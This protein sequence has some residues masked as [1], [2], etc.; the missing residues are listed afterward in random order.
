MQYLKL[1]SGK[2]PRIL[3]AD[4]RQSTPLNVDVL[5]SISPRTKLGLTIYYASH[6]FLNDTFKDIKGSREV[7]L[8]LI[9]PKWP[10]EDMSN[11][12]GRI[13]QQNNVKKLSMVDPTL[14]I[15]ASDHDG[16]VLSPLFSYFGQ[17]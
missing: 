11:V 14:P 7:H 17:D 12:V 4:I 15:N 16:L 2:F 10:T 1:H 3:L 5:K 9:N 8:E 13:V 6:D